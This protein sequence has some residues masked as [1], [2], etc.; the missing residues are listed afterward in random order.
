V[1]IGAVLGASTAAVAQTAAP[2]PARKTVVPEATPLAPAFSQWV[3]SYRIDEPLRAPFAGAVEAVPLVIRVPQGAP[4]QPA[5]ASTA[6]LTPQMQPVILTLPELPLIGS[7]LASAGRSWSPNFN[8]QGLTASIVVLDAAGG[9]KE[10]RPLNAPLR[11]DERFKIRIMPTFDA[12]ARVDQLIGDTWTAQRAGQIYPAT[13]SVVQINANETVE[14]PLARNEFFV[15]NG[16]GVDRVALSLRSMARGN[17]STQPLYRQDLA[18]YSTFQQLLPAGS[19][20]SMEFM[21]STAK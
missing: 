12:Y 5:V 1:A 9:F 8:Y 2:A 20:P 14:L 11:A 18:G 16:R 6:A 15:M 3:A 21:I 17:A 19:L 13:D 7:D 4:A 10:F